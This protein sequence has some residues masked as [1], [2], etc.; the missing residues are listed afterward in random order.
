MTTHDDSTPA[1]GSGPDDDYSA[2]VL[3]SH[4]IQGPEP[5]ETGTVR[6]QSPEPDETGTVRI[7]SPEPGETG[8]LR[9]Q[10]GQPEKTVPAVSG[11]GAGELGTVRLGDRGAQATVPAGE[12][13][14]ASVEAGT[15]R[16]PGSGSGAT[17]TLRIQG[18]GSQATVPAGDQSAASVEAGTVRVPG[19]GSGATGTVRLGGRGPQATVPAGDQSAASAEAGTVRGP[20]PGSG[21]TGTLRSQ[22]PGAQATVPGAL[23]GGPEPDRVEGAVLRF[24]PGVTAALA[25]RTLRQVS[26]VAE[27][28]A[29]RPRPGLRRYALPA[30]VLLCVLAFLAWQRLGSSVEV[31]SVSVVARPAV[32]GCDTTSDIVA[33]VTTD[34]SP[35]TLTYRWIRSDGTASGVLRETLARGQREARLHLRWTFEGEGHL[36]GQADLR[37]L[38][39]TSRTVTAQIT[40][41]CP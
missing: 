3:A 25:E 4:W 24:G 5:D 6:I 31:R 37:L 18:P 40:Y 9:M 2:T 39:P 13:S 10:D 21:A 36:T 30:V 28:P 12:Q 16:V 33:R 7:Q 22:G 19:S 11:P 41:D 35:G 27:P 17:G 23:E 32:L 38:T 20:G 15:V 26:V 1:P 29:A 14:A 34:G 8:T